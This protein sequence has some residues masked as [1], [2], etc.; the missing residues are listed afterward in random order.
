MAFE[1]DVCMDF[2][3]L[4]YP[5]PAIRGSFVDGIGE[6]R[7]QQWLNVKSAVEAGVPYSFGS[8][9]PASLEP[10]LNGFFQMQGFVTR[11]RKDAL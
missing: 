11:L 3:T 2:I 7:Y 10:E 8:D 1:C 9:W 4:Q 6:E 5:H